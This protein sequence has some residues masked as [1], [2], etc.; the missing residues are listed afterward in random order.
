MKP[1]IKLESNI[2]T[3]TQNNVCISMWYTFPYFQICMPLRY[4]SMM[5]ELAL[6]SD[7]R[8][9]PCTKTYYVWGQN[10]FEFAYH[11]FPQNMFAASTAK[12]V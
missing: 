6:Y 8:Y 2:K 5:I 4:I 3:R 9:V 11:I 12:I 7:C 1:F 10:Y